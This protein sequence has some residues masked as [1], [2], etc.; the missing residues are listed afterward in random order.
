MSV[1][2][3]VKPKLSVIVGP[4]QPRKSDPLGVVDFVFGQVTVTNQSGHRNLVSFV[5][6]GITISADHRY[7][8]HRSLFAM[9]PVTSL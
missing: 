1:I 9:M 2:K 6:H 8:K 7:C 3:L 4:L 5:L